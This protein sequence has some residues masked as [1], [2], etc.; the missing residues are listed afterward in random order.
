MHGMFIPASSTT[1]SSV[2]DRTVSQ[3]R[4]PDGRPAAVEQLVVG[5]MSD[6][7]GAQPRRGEKHVDCDAVE[8]LVGRVGGAAAAGAVDRIDVIVIGAC[9]GDGGGR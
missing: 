3:K 7:A 8:L 6:S 9:D 5:D 4:R 1:V 2:V